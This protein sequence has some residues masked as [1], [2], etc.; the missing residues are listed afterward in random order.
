MSELRIFSHVRNSIVAVLIAAI[1]ATIVGG[2]PVI[3]DD[4]QDW[5]KKLARKIAK[6][7]IYPRSAL[8]REIEGK[9]RVKIVI[10]REGAITSYEIIQP[11]GESIL[12]KAIPK[13]MKKLTPLPPPPPDLPASSLTLVI[14]ITWRLQ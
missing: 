9:A 2:G 13:M 14:P 1:A 12:D 3:A 10:D 7:H 5:R 8:S 6:K 4:V 11:S